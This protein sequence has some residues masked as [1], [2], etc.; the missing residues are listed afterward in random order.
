MKVMLGAVIFALFYWVGMWIKQWFNIPLPANIIGLLLLV[1]ALFGKVI[2]LSWVEDCGRLALKHM[3]LFFIPSIVGTLAFAKLMAP[4]WLPILM[5]VVA[6]TWLVM[7]V[8]GLV[9]K[10]SA[11]KE[12]SADESRTLAQ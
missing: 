6:G 7:V 4:Q 9:T 2:K 12:R 3:G 8:T 1:A 5:S 11:R 10:Y